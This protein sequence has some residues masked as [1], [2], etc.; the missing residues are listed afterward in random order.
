MSG[1]QQLTLRIEIAKAF[2]QFYAWSWTQNTWTKD[3]VH[4]APANQEVGINNPFFQVQFDL[5]SPE[6]SGNGQRHTSHGHP[7]N[8]S[9]SLSRN[10]SLKSALIALSK[11][12]G[13]CQHLQARQKDMPNSIQSSSSSNRSESLKTLENALISQ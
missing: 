3:V 5:A 9:V 13:L 7:F 12:S 2:W 1:Q 6:E 4:F 11:S 10:P 8:P